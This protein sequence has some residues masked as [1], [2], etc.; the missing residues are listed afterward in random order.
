[1]YILVHA[2]HCGGLIAMTR[3]QP[4]A[5]GVDVGTSGCKAIILSSGGRLLYTAQASYPTRRT[6]A[7]E[8]TQ[9]PDDWL[10][11]VRETLRE[12][13]TAAAGRSIIGIG[14][15]APAHAAVLSDEAG[16]AL[17]PSLL[18]FD[19]RPASTAEALKAHYGVALFEATFVDLSA[20][21]TLAQLA[22]LHEQS[23]ELWPKIRW[24]LTQKDWIRFRLTGVALID[25]SDAAG[26]AMI[27]QTTRSWLEPVC[28]DLGLR[29][30]QLPP[31]VDSTAAGGSLTRDWADGTGLPVDTPVV[32]GATDT[33]A[34]L[35]SVG[36][37]SA[38][39]SLVKIAS[40]G[41]VVGVSARPIVERRLLTYPHPVPGQWYTLAATNTATVAY[42]WL[43]ETVFA[44]QVAEPAVTYEDINRRASRVP[45]GSEGVLFLPFLEGER[46]P[47][48]DAHLRASFLGLSA[49]HGR[50][51]LARDVLE[52][53]AMALRCCRD[54]VVAAGLPVR[55]PFLA[56]GGTSSKLWRRILASALAEPGVLADPQG[57]AIGA[58]IL[59]MSSGA[60]T[61]AEIASRVPTPRTTVVE[62]EP[63]WISVYDALHQTYRLAAEAITPVSH[64]LSGAAAEPIDHA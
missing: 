29:P 58:A 44:A 20:G 13:A 42:Q 7:G 26:T 61:A 9:R 22:W 15:T 21:W 31:I 53:V 35:L 6:V 25:A 39:A 2:S 28:A 11:A 54:V 23:P 3:R 30:E 32:V 17:A 55:S 63:D 8:V 14:I 46:T 49:A 60:T 16:R 24:L 10:K 51:H 19:A 12:C 33:A 18:A 48:W 34:E 52:G 1:M 57:P 4:V 41:T 64:Q 47:Y 50:D 43:R 56:G 62:P 37:V 40:T 59:A 45:A 38:G 36:A 5:I 27:D